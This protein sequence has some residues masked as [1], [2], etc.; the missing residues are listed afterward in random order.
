MY[1]AWYFNCK[2][3]CSSRKSNSSSL[4]EPTSFHPCKTLKIIF[5]PPHETVKLGLT[6]KFAREERYL[7]KIKRQNKYRTES[8]KKKGRV[9]KRCKVS[10]GKKLANFSFLA[11]WSSGTKLI[12]YPFFP[13]FLPRNRSLITKEREKRNYFV[14]SVAGSNRGIHPAWSV[15]ADSASRTP[16]TRFLDCS[17]VNRESNENH[18]IPVYLCIYIYV[19]SKFSARTTARKDDQKPGNKG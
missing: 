3:T 2:V 18:Y 13:F 6:P 5:Y 1:I 12:S 9:I 19:C 11:R 4:D 8:S 10:R 15:F 7:K 14:G 16:G 17:P